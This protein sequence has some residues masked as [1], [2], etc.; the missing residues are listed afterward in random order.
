MKSILA[1]LGIAVLT[2]VPL[3]QSQVQQTTGGSQKTGQEKETVS[4]L[5][6]SVEE[7]DERLQNLENTTQQLQ[8]SLAEL[9]QKQAGTTPR[10]PRTDQLNQVRSELASS[11]CD[12]DFNKAAAMAIENRLPSTT[13]QGAAAMN[14]TE[15]LRRIVEKLVQALD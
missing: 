15:R 14:C 8:V 1:L 6:A 7:L 12:A 9:Q 2:A 13:Y 4:K 11:G 5:R 3:G 10:H